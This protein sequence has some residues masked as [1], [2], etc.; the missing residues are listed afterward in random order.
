[1]QNMNQAMHQS[2]FLRNVASEGK[3]IAKKSLGQNFLVSAEI[4]EKIASCFEVSDLTNIIEIGT[5]LGSLTFFLLQRTHNFVGIEKDVELNAK[6]GEI[7][8]GTN[9]KFLNDDAL[10]FNFAE[11]SNKHTVIVSN[12]PYNVGTK[13]LLHIGTTTLPKISA[14]VVMLQKDVIEKITAKHGSKNYHQLGVFFQTFCEI[15]QICVVGQACFSPAPN[16]LS[17]VVKISPIKQIPNIEQYWKFLH[18]AFSYNRKML[19]TIFD[20]TIDE[21][22]AKKRPSELKPKEFLEVFECIN[23]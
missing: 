20:E 18:K 1:M 7:F 22:F 8:A 17:A 21:K 5:G 11:I 2:E 19:S 14:M 23:H 10:R 15:E 16:V 13:I 4:I 6:L 12:L 3:K 9:A